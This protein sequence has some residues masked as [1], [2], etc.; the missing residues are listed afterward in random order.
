VLL[1]AFTCENEP[2]EGDFSDDTDLS[3]EIA[4]QNTQDAAVD[5]LDVT[6]ETY[7]QLCIAYR[8]ALE[9]QIEFCGDS[10]GSLQTQINSIGDCGVTNPDPCETVTASAAE[11][12]TA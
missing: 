11:A 4:A 9:I 3:C 10:D 7:M 6:D 12:E 8:N 1:T 2:L 5:F